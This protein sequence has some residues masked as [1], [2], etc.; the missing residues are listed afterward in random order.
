[1]KAPLPT[2]FVLALVQPSRAREELINRANC[3]SR[4]ESPFILRVVPTLT[5]FPQPT[6][7]PVRCRASSHRKPEAGVSSQTHVLPGAESKA[8]FLFS[9]AE[10]GQENSLVLC[11]LCCGSRSRMTPLIQDWKL[12]PSALITFSHV[13]FRPCTRV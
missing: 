1:M 8:A 2:S 11:V 5:T 10:T 7:L 13:T 6:R 12:R 9:S 4:L 3:W